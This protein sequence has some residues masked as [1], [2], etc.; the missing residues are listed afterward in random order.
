M[1][2]LTSQIITDRE[3]A[4][5]MRKIREEHTDQLGKK[6]YRQ[7]I[8]AAD[9]DEAV[10]LAVGATQLDG[11]LIK[12]EQNKYISAI[13]SGS[14]P[15]RDAGN[16]AVTPDFNSRNAMLSVVLAHFLSDSKPLSFATSVPYLNNLSDAE[17]IALLSVDQLKV[18]EIR[19]KALSVANM[20][21]D[22]NAYVAPLEV[23]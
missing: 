19:A 6:H 4:G 3:Q 22:V 8:A 17:L 13:E 18:D 12:Q 5:G 23:E 15:F 20:S 21:A 2:I 10:G 7:F 1:T 16:N 11:S 9:Y 14:N